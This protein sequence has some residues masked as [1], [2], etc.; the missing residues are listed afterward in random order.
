L[1]S[2]YFPCFKNTIT[3]SLFDTGKPQLLSSKNQNLQWSMVLGAYM[4]PSNLYPHFNF[5]GLARFSAS[6]LFKI[7]LMFNRSHFI[8]R[9][10]HFSLSSP[11]RLQKKFSNLTIEAELA[12]SNATEVTTTSKHDPNLRA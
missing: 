12:Q 1:V 4:L 11:I 10:N 7:H 5:V 3:T 6:K 8:K 2:I 9:P